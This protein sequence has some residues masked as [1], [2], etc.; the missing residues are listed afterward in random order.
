MNPVFRIG[1]GWD[2]HALVPG[3]PLVIGGVQI[4]F[5]LGLLG[6]SDA[7]VLLHAI[8]CNPYR[9]SLKWIELNAFNGYVA[10]DITRCSELH[11]LL[12]CIV[13]Q[14]DS[15]LGLCFDYAEAEFC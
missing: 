13:L 10:I 5:A 8:Y 9:I 2:V 11:Y 1:Q 14:P 3:R 7:D 6:H 12:R 4:P 15:E